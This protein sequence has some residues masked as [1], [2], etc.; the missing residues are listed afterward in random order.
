MN[1]IS[2]TKRSELLLK[3]GLLLSLMIGY[4]IYSNLDSLR[5]YF[6]DW[7]A[8]RQTNGQVI[9]SNIEGQGLHG[10]WRFDITYSYK[11]GNQEFSSSRVH[12][13]YQATENPSYAESYVKKYPVGKHI[14]VFYEENNPQNSVLE[15][16]V[17]WDG[18]L[19]SYLM[20]ILLPITVFGL[21]LYFDIKSRR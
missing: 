15:P 16:Q 20:L 8:F 17:K 1:K 18:L 13:G 6:V 11:V 9:S 5:W 21:A 19:N 7:R 4:G 14:T 2:D 12:Y 10:G 3:M